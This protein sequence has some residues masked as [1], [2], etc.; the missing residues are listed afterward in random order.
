M[1]LRVLKKDI[2]QQVLEIVKHEPLDVKLVVLAPGVQT[3]RTALASKVADVTVQVA[4][5]DSLR[6]EDA[7]RTRDG[8]VIVQGSLKVREIELGNLDALTLNRD[9][10]YSFTGV[11]HTFFTWEYNYNAGTGRED[12]RTTYK[13]SVSPNGTGS[14]EVLD[15]VTT[16]R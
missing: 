3:L 13:I 12:T 14:Y 4:I 10:S 16:G 5:T 7:H 6:F 11:H 2:P 15:S 8:D 1:S 9:G